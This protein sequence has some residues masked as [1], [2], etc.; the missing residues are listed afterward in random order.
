VK[1]GGSSL[2]YVNRLLCKYCVFFCNRN[3][4]DSGRTGTLDRDEFV[5]GMWRVDEELRRARTHALKSASA[6]SLASFRGR[7]RPSHKPKPILR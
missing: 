5:N 1:S 3:E 2:C 7:S 6:S 4:C